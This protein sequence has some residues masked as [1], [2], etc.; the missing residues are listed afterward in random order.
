MEN[1]YYLHDLKD[2]EEAL[3]NPKAQWG[4]LEDSKVRLRGVGHPV[5]RAEHI[6]RV[7][8]RLRAWEC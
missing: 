8:G 3:T 5:T 7:H 2:V 1:E 4:D 6:G